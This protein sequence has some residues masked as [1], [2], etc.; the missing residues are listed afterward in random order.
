MNYT[1]KGCQLFGYYYKKQNGTYAHV[2][3]HTHWRDELAP[4]KQAK[5]KRG[6]YE[7]RIQNHG[8]KIWRRLEN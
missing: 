7:I 6:I 5:Y 8:K 2:D 4:P 1:G 3:R